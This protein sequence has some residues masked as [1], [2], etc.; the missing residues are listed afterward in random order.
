MELISE[1]DK[2]QPKAL[3]SWPNVLWLVLYTHQ[4]RGDVA[5]VWP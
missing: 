2:P 4:C 1:P 3:T 5:E